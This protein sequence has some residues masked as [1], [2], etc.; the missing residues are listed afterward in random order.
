MLTLAE[1]TQPEQVRCF[2][3]EDELVAARV[4]EAAT[5]K[6]YAVLCIDRARAY[7]AK[8][9]TM[10]VAL[11]LRAWA[12]EM[13]ALHGGK[14]VIKVHHNYLPWLAGFLVTRY[15]EAVESWPDATTDEDVKRARE[16]K[17]GQGRGFSKDV[18]V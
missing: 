2:Q 1:M 5:A 6:E 9:A 8:I 10:T 3:I 7:E 17:T 4:M 18:K 14:T 15:G 13:A 11:Y 16:W 12:V